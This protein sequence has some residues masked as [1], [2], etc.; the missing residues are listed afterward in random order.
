MKTLDNNQ[1]ARLADYINGRAVNISDE[2]LQLLADDD[3]LAS[4]CIEIAEIA[5]EASR[6]GVV[7]PFDNTTTTQRPAQKN[8]GKTIRMIIMAAAACLVIAIAIQFLT[9]NDTTT[10]PT[11]T[12]STDTEQQP[13]PRKR[14]MGILSAKSLDKGY[15]ELPEEFS[16]MIQSAHTKGYFDFEPETPFD[17]VF[18]APVKPDTL[19]L[20]SP[21]VKTPLMVLPVSGESVTISPG[22]ASGLYYY[23]LKYNLKERNAIAIGTED[24]TAQ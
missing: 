24:E 20:Y 14:S 10:I 22:L 3:Q 7:V 21:R 23:Y 8:N 11:D 18:S 13:P 5:A 9:K 15:Y 1:K 17:I 19:Y 16:K 6:E 4:E 2:E 12:A